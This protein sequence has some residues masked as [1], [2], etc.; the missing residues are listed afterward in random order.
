MEAPSS[1]VDLVVESL[2]AY[3]RGD[4]DTLRR[5]LDPEAEICSEPGMINSGT[6]RGFDGIPD[7]YETAEKALDAVHQMAEP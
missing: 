7:L 5:L 3:Q 2:A 4:E 1:K 6:Y